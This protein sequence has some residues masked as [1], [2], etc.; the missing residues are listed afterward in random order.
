M[1]WDKMCKALCCCRKSSV[2]VPGTPT[3]PANSQVRIDVSIA[4]IKP[5]HRYN[6]TLVDIHEALRVT[7]LEGPTR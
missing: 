3:T 4:R 1:S 7:I 6:E 5:E 2:V